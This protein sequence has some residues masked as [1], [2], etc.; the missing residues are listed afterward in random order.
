MPGI[1]STGY[2]KTSLARIIIKPG[3]GKLR[4]N[5]KAAEDYFPSRLTHM[6]FLEPFVTVNR[7]DQY[8]I[9]AKITGGGI[10]SQADAL[11]HAIAK[12]LSEFDPSFKQLL[13]DKGFITRDARIKERVKAGLR[14]ARKAR[15]YRK[16]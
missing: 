8:D 10:S 5:G 6:R 16:R 3:T 1:L 2:R 7:K 4:I 14:G 12:A 9:T 13:R 15:Q 11:R